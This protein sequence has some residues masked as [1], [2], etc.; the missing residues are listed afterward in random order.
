[1]SPKVPTPSTTGTKAREA[2]P[3]WTRSDEDQKTTILGEILA[4]EIH[5]TPGKILAGDHRDATARPLPEPR[6]GPCRRHLRGHNQ[7]RVR[8]DSTVVPIQ[9]PAQP[10]G[11]APA[12]QRAASKPAQQAPVWWHADLREGSTTAPPQQLACL[13]GAAHTAGLGACRSEAER[14]RTG[15]ASFTSPIKLMDT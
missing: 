8:Q 15:R 11:P 10:A 6:Q 1:M 2:P 9:L 7:A 4:E 5:E 3:W 12:R 13:H 14:R